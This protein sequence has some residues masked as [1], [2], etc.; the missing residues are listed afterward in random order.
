MNPQNSTEKLAK[1]PVNNLTK[2]L[3]EEDEPGA[4]PCN[5]VNGFKKK[6]EVVFLHFRLWVA[7]LPGFDVKF[8]SSM[9][10]SP[11]GQVLS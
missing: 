3:P 5:P 1:D 2:D 7:D 11:R 9:S 6:M 4:A 10:K 8:V